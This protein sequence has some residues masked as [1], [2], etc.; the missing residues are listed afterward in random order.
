MSPT[1]VSAIFEQMAEYWDDP[2]GFVLDSFPWGQEGELANDSGPDEWQTKILTDIGIAAQKNNFNGVDPVAAIQF[3]IASGHG[4]GKSTLFAWLHWWIMCTRPNAKGRVTANT[5]TQLE[6]TTW[7]EIQRWWKLLIC[8]DCFEVT[9]SKAYHLENPEGWFS[10][11]ITCAEENSEAFAGQHNKESTSFFLFDES[12]LIPDKIFEVAA[13][14]LTD[15]EPMW[16]CAGNPTRN[17][18]EFYEICFGEKAHRWNVRSIDSRTCKFPNHQL[19]DEW[20]QDYGIDSDYVRVRILGKPPRQAEDQLIGRDLVDSARIREVASCEDEPLIAGVDVPDGGAAWF[21]VRFRRGLDSRPGP[22]V[23][24]PF[25]LPGERV[26]RASMVATLARMLGEQDRRSKIAMMFVDSQ[27]G[28]AIV[29]RLHAL[30]YQNV[31]EVSFA[32]ASSRPPVQGKPQFANKRAEMWGGDIKE[33]LARGAIDPNDAILRK[34]LS[35]PGF[36]YSV[37][38]DGAL[39]VESKADMKKRG[40][41]SPDDADALALTFAFPVVND[42][43]DTYEAPTRRGGDAWMRR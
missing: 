14:G 12:S 10:K 17:T 30:G 2:L 22:W 20:I 31:Q 4:I 39:V 36:H 34:Q 8:R 42:R 9:G 1:E 15:G 7:A 28:A 32:G 6:T 38:G 13:A 23:P 33:W 41:A 16:F 5:Y 21:V 11:P 29:E 25:R 35:S 27:P 26:D 19:H 18:G 40:I 37:G 3:A 43:R 24:T